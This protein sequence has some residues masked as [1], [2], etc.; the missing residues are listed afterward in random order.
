MG[1]PHPFTSTAAIGHWI[2]GARAA[3]TG[4]RVQ[5]VWNPA[6]G[7][8]ARRVLLG[9]EADVAA[10]VA[11]AS[12]AQPAWADTPPIRRARVINR[13]RHLDTASVLQVLMDRG[14][15]LS[16][17]KPAAAPAPPSSA[18]SSGERR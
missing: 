1:A 9:T 7:E 13:L 17:G 6:T 15:E 4:T 5:T 18:S 14:L 8:A 3:G 11:A 12:K 10:A 2:G 16:G